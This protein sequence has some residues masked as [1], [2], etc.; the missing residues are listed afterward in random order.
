MQDVLE[1][2]VDACSLPNTANGVQGVRVK[3]EAGERGGKESA[4]I[5]SNDLLRNGRLRFD[6]LR[7]DL[8]PG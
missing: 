3:E 1:W 6:I 8:A 4:A 5:V 7:G 2:F